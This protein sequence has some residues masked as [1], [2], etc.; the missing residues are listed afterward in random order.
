MAGA[1]PGAA[2]A[3]LLALYRGIVRMHKARLPPEMRQIGD[4]YVR[5]EFRSHLRSKNPVTP[6]QWGEFRQQWAGYLAML[7][8]PGMSQQALAAHPQHAA[9]PLAH[10]PGTASAI[11]AVRQVSEGLDVYLNPEQKLRMEALRKEAAALGHSMLAGV[12]Q[13]TEEPP[14]PGAQPLQ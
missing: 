13:A 7:S 3:E 5:Q 9:P 1:S 2:L 10:K 8:P 4:S 14:M 6:A 12:P 11:D